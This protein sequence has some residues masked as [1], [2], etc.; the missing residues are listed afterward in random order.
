MKKS[1]LLLI[2]F[3]FCIGR[4]DATTYYI[5]CVNGNDGN[6]GTVPNSAWQ[7]IKRVN[8]F[9]LFNPNDTISF[10]CG[11]RIQDTTLIPPSD[12]LIFNSYGSGAKP[13]ID[14][15]TDTLTCMEITRNNIHINGLKFVGGYLDRTPF[16]RH[17]EKQVY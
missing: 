2:L 5:D 1:I 9:Q 16:C 17:S 14:G 7:H 4:L 10:K 6:L 8:K 3:L 12:N 15:S 13:I 11:T